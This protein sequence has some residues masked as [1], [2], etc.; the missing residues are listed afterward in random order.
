MDKW[1]HSKAVP[2]ISSLDNFSQKNTMIAGARSHQEVWQNQQG[3]YY[4]VSLSWQ[5]EQLK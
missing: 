1:N 3:T 2:P 4:S 5:R